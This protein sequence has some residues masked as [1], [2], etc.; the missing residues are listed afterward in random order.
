MTEQL[1]LVERKTNRNLLLG[2]AVQQLQD[3]NRNFNP[4]TNAAQVQT[5][6]S[7]EQ[8][9][10]M[11]M[12][13]RNEIA[14]MFMGLLNVMKQDGMQSLNGAGVNLKTGSLVR[15]MLERVK[16][17]EN[18]TVK[19]ANIENVPGGKI[20]KAFRDRAVKGLMKALRDGARAP[21]TMAGRVAYHGII[22]PIPIVIQHS[23]GIFYLL[24]C[25]FFCFVVIW[26]VRYYYVEY[27]EDER[28]QALLSIVYGGGQYVIIPAQKMLNLIQ[29]IISNAFIQMGRN[30]PM[31]KEQ[32]QEQLATGMQKVGELAKY[33][34]CA[35]L[36]G[37]LKSWAG[38]N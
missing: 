9:K 38:C 14:G 6:L 5:S 11:F 17:I 7:E 8:V 31:V 26:N 15:Q 29:T 21:F 22:M 13:Q 28:A 36:P 30:L 23:G 33:A 16:V 10:K 37:Y 2:S 25:Y 1:Q 19:K 32:A 20:P 35:P 18:L 3:P 4:E 34:Y 27:A 24:Y 12:N